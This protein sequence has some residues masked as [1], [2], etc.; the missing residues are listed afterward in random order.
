MGFRH[1]I[2]C[3]RSK[4]GSPVDFW[5]PATGISLGRWLR[6]AWVRVAHIGWQRVRRSYAFGYT[7]HPSRESKLFHA[8]TTASTW[9]SFARFYFQ[10]LFVNFHIS[11][12]RPRLPAPRGFSGLCPWAIIRIAVPCLTSPNGSSPVKTSTTNIANANISACS[13]PV[14]CRYPFS[15]GGSITSGANHLEISTTPGVVAIVNTQ[16]S[17]MVGPTRASASR[18][19]YICLIGRIGI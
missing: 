4:K 18:D 14:G 8:V 1:R 16:A 3:V 5:A 10:H 2:Y 19:Q 6:R 11:V 13:I 15:R 12:G 17:G 9:G 7:T